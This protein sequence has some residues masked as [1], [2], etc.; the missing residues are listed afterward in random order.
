MSNLRIAGLI[1]G[2]LGLYLTFRFFRGQ[3][4]KRTNFF[5]FGVFSSLLILVSL[6]PDFLN[7]VTGM[8]AL[9]KEH[10]GRVIFLLIFSNIIL[11]F[12]VLYF[13]TKIDKQNYQFDLLIRSLGKERLF[14]ENIKDKEIGIIIPA[15]NEADNLK[16]LLRRIPERIGDREVGV[17][18]V[19]D[20]SDDNTAQ[21]ARKMGCMVVR[22]KINRGQGAASRLGYDILLADNNIKVGVTMD[23][24]NQHL[25]EEI[26]R[27]VNPILEDR[28]DLVVGSRNLG[29]K[30]K[31]S[32]L[33]DVGL[34]F[35]S[36]VISFLSGV[37]L[38]DCASGFK[39]FNVDKM[40]MLNLKEDQFQAA[41]VI[42]EAAKRGLRIGE[43][44]ITI[45]KRKH[46]R[47]KKGKE[48]GYALSFAKTILKTWWR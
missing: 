8:L 28:Y 30:E 13:K 10:Q 37:K 33:R 5:F 17:L 40:R 44:P 18:V 12:L 6:F 2:I 15:F 16:E 11:W 36:K 41:E 48:W 42:I 26:D 47:T 19:D 23:A 32:P 14:K 4:W 39:A 9:E 20:G 7:A 27:L 1:I 46:G 25:P 38:T 3:R 35:F 22:N 45:T 34:S 24:D 31:Y 43:V 21:A 29:K